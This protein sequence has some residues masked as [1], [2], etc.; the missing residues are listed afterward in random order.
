MVIDPPDLH[1][2]P[3]R[4]NGHTRKF[5]S[6]VTA[7]Q[8]TSVA[9]VKHEERERDDIEAEANRVFKKRRTSSE[10]PE[11]QKEDVKEHVEAGDQ[12]CDIAERELQK[13]LQDI[14]REVEADPDGPDWEDLDAEDADDPMMVSEYVTEIFDHLKIVEVRFSRFHLT[15]IH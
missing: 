13:H 15:C 6:S 7:A 5:S 11:D 2:P 1:V 4:V 8:K 10:P 12:V 3:T 9:H 14:G